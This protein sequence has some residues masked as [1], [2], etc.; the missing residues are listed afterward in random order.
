MTAIYGSPTAPRVVFTTNRDNNQEIYAMRADGSGQIN[1]TND[2]GSD[3]EP[4][5]SPDGS[6]IAFTSD[7]DG[8]PEIYVMR[9]DGSDPARLTDHPGIDASPAWSPGG[10][11]IAFISDRS[12][13]LELHLMNPDGSGVRQVTQNGAREF[14]WSPDGSRIAYRSYTTRE[15]YLVG[16]DGSGL[17]QLTESTEAYGPPAW[18]PEGDRIALSSYHESFFGSVYLV[19]GDGSGFQRVSPEITGGQFAW[20]PDGT[21]MVISGSNPNALYVVDLATGET[22]DV[23]DGRTRKPVWLPDGETIGFYSP[24]DIYMV[25]T[26]GR[27]LPV[28]LTNNPGFESDLAWWWPVFRE[29]FTDRLEEGWAWTNEDRSAW[30]LTSDGQLMILAGDAMLLSTENGQRNV[31]LRDAP[32]GDFEITARVSA[33]PSVDFQ[34]AAI[35]IYQDDDNFIAINRGFCSTC[36]GSGIYVDNEIEGGFLHEGREIYWIPMDAG[37]VYLRLRRQGDTYTPSYRLPGE[38]WIEL[39]PLERVLQ[40]VKVGLG[41]TNADVSGLVGDL[42]ASFDFFTLREI[43]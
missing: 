13:R 41:A 11:Q 35:L 1:L 36:V 12:G 37:E 7:R 26:G 43:D 42:V 38:A 16:E 8:N 18:S 20:S 30:S 27:A 21:Q 6:R 24:D 17:L 34:Q 28:N 3:R 25:K 23:Y 5:W 32:A 40:P 15:F 31:L 19:N 14:A 22:A 10:G 9:A 39:P 2:L 33:Q 29:D 4:A